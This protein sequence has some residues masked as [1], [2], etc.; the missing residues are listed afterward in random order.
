MLSWGGHEGR[1]GY[2]Q[3]RGEGTHRPRYACSGPV[4]RRRLN[5]RDGPRPRAPR[6][7]PAPSEEEGQSFRDGYTPAREHRHLHDFPHGRRGS[8]HVLVAG[9]DAHEAPAVRREEDF[10]LTDR[11]LRGHS[12]WGRVPTGASSGEARARHEREPEAHVRVCSRTRERERGGTSGRGRR[13]KDERRVSPSAPKLSDSSI[14][15]FL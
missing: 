5:S 12:I 7:R 8:Q 10:K 9:V 3:R 15:L 6:T 4:G 11:S 13:V 1:D 2:E 14:S